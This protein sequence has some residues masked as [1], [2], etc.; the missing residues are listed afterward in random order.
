M[1][2][3]IPSLNA[4]HPQHFGTFITK[5]LPQRRIAV[6]TSEVM[7]R[8]I[9]FTHNDARKLKKC[10]C[11][12]TGSRQMLEMGRDV[13]WKSELWSNGGSEK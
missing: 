8:M 6:F 7:Q 2:N 4:R 12:T 13:S 9:H 11:F 3:L 1:R 10:L 5:I